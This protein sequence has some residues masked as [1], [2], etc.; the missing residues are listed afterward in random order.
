MRNFPVLLWGLCSSCVS[1][2][3][4]PVRT[5]GCEV[6]FPRERRPC[7]HPSSR[8]APLLTSFFR[9]HSFHLSLFVLPPWLPWVQEPGCNNGLLCSASS[10]NQLPPPRP[11]D[12]NISVS[13]PHS[14]SSPS[15]P[16]LPSFRRWDIMACAFDGGGIMR[17]RSAVMSLDSF[18]STFRCEKFLHEAPGAD[19]CPRY[20]AARISLALAV[21]AAC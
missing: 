15:V 18:G 8:L 6:D 5:P 11:P 13:F 7:P 4:F 21:L 1:C 2:F 16:C 19:C 3:L 12:P 20:A 10:Y 9:S 14:S 17:C